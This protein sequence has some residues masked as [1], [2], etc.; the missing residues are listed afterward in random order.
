MNKSKGILK[1]FQE[2]YEK[3]APAGLLPPRSLKSERSVLGAMMIDSVSADMAI[4][5]IGIRTLENSPF[6]RQTH[7]HIYLAITALYEAHEP[8]DLLTVTNQLK[9]HGT[10]DEVGGSSFVVELTTQVVTVAHVQTHARIILQ[11]H[12][13]REGIRICE[14]IKLK[15]FEGETDEFELM[16]ELEAGA[17]SLVEVKRG[18]GSGFQT[19]YNVS[20]QTIKALG[21]VR[22]N[23]LTGITT[24]IPMLDDM[25]NGWQRGD[26]IILAARPS[27]GKSALA[28]SLARAASLSAASKVSTAFISLEMSGD[29]LVMRLLCSEASVNMQRARRGR[30]DDRDWKD[31]TKAHGRFAEAGIHISTAHSVTASDI[32]SSVRHLATKLTKTDKP[33]GLVIIDYITLVQLPGKTEYR[34]E[35]GDLAKSLK[36]LGG[37]LNCAMIVL[38]QLS[39]KVEDRKVRRPML[40]DLRESGELEQ[41]ADCVLLIY[42]PEVDGIEYDEQRQISTKNLA[43]LILAKQ[44]NGP[45]GTVLS[46]F[47]KE[48]SSFEEWPTNLF[49]AAERFEEPR[50]AEHGTQEAF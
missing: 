46:Q 42:R 15:L 25:T 14:E 22:P 39:R 31:V 26:L 13:A 7:T 29:Q 41:H 32:R 44:R 5:T 17:G 48:E 40:S 28:M 30:M 23:E 6:Y 45:T 34:R 38:S 21:E 36:N 1:T 9:K 47:I 43:E 8:I 16:S 35:L 50:R 33:L 11:K 18:G 20:Q 19:L 27:V 10:F 37:E 4:S 12:V 3:L 24:G 49:E 2:L